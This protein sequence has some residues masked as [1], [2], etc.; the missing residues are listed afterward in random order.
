MDYLCQSISSLKSSLAHHHALYS[1]YFLYTCSHKN[2]DSLS[3]NLRFT[4]NGLKF[5][6]ATPMHM[7][8]KNTN[9]RP[10]TCAMSSGEF[11]L[12][13]YNS[14]SLMSKGL[15]FFFPFVSSFDKILSIP[16]QPIQI[17]PPS[18]SRVSSAPVRETLAQTVHD[19]WTLN[20]LLLRYFCV[21][22][23]YEN[24]NSVLI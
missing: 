14:V 12:T 9:Y 13:A 16:L 20:S 4:L 21:K 11:F 19:S 7:W 6:L 8:L 23:A 2:S 18:L 3:A 1:V 15:P 17:V 22:S 24:V 10:L 5:G